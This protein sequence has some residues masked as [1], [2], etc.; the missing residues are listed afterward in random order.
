MTR[1]FM[2][3]LMSLDQFPLAPSFAFLPASLYRLSVLSV[4]SL[5]LFKIVRTALMLLC[6]V[7]AS[8]QRLE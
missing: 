8:T 2:H 4:N 3:P 6:Y 5:E 7:T 1:H